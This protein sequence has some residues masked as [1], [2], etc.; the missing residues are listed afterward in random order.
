MK[1]PI[2][3]LVFSLIVMYLPTG[4]RAD[5]IAPCPPP[6]STVKTVE[7]PREVPAL[8]LKAFK[9]HVGDIAS[10]GEKFDST[11]VV[12]TGR[13]RRV[14]FV[15]NRGPDY[16]V[17]TEHGGMGYNDPIFVYRVD[18]QNFT[19]KLVS[20]EITFPATVCKV[21]QRLIDAK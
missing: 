12:V 9:E 19:A 1:I 20:E 17:A 21:A 13:N 10:P 7:F 6:D 4:A 18:P 2:A 16:L 3:P 15:W 14:I 8:V 5:C 11:D